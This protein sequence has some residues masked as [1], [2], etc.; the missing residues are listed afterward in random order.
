VAILSYC[1]GIYLEGP[2]KSTKDLSK[3]LYTDRDSNRTSP[4]YKSRTLSFRQSDCYMKRAN[5][6]NP[7][8]AV[9]APSY[10][11][12]MQSQYSAPMQFLQSDVTAPCSPSILFLCSF[13]SLILLP[14]VVPV[15][16]QFLHPDV[17]APCSPSSYVVSTS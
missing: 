6:V 5:Y 2:R 4:E 14:H 9:S 17:T 12:S 8:Y 11:C 3:N 7:D 1:P 10:F 16:M 15:T 13:Y